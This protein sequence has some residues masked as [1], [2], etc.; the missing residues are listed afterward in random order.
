MVQ[1]SLSLAGTALHYSAIVTR[2]S[3]FSKLCNETHSIKVALMNQIGP[4]IMKL[5]STHYAGTF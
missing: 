2:V 4:I 3:H 5:E 1:T